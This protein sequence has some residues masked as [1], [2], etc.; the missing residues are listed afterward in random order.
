VITGEGERVEQWLKAYRSKPLALGTISR[1]GKNQGEWLKR[2]NGLVH[3]MNSVEEGVM[4]CEKGA[5]RDD[6]N[7]GMGSLELSDR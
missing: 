1:I 6:L 5:C 3:G 7:L 2:R 4:V